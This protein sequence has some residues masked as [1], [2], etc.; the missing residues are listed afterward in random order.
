MIAFLSAG[1]ALGIYAGISPGPL[2]TL[3]ISHS[4][5]HGSREGAKVA[6]APLITDFPILLVSTL[7]L[8]RFSNYQW[9]LGLVSM[10]GGTFL[11][12][13]A[14]TSIKT[15]GIEIKLDGEAPP[16]SLMKGVLVNALSPNPYVFWTTIG[17]PTVLKGLSVGY[18][19]PLLFI[20]SFLGCLIGSKMILAVIAGKS[21]Q[22]LKGK[23]YL[24]IMRLLGIILLVYAFI[25][26]RD[27]F[28]LLA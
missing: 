28:N 8:M 21:R 10:M 16:Y 20:G 12:Y 22:F 25:L 4:I 18:M 5:R 26:L 24:Y 2:M 17:A 27:G 19:A 1:A 9:V 7:L 23:T 13:L 6:F 3:V 11:L 15:K 14:Y